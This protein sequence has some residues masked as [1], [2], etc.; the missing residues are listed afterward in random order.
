MAAQLGGGIIV[1]KSVPWA[2]RGKAL[3]SIKTQSFPKGA[4]PPHLV[5][6]VERFK[7]AVA[8]C[9]GKIVKG[10]GSATVQGFNACLSA[11]LRG[12]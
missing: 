1:Y 12:A 3:L 7:S 11:R 6:Y 4:V 5:P 8:E 2:K 9:R 10:R